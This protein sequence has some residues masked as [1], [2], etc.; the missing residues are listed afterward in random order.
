M[1]FRVGINLGDVLVDEDGDIFGEGVNVAARIEALAEPGG[2]YLSRFARD[3]IRDRMEIDLEDKG[4]VEVKNIA[5]PVRVF[6][7]LGK[8]EEAN[9]PVQAPQQRPRWQI[10]AAIVGLIVLVPRRRRRLVVEQA[11]GLRAGGP[12]E[13]CV[14]AAG[15]TKHCGA[16]V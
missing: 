8:G 15:K 11:T 10:S 5:R 1:L 4:E 9:P 7:V 2:I 12:S 6:R 16:A 13:I 14:Q 3:Q